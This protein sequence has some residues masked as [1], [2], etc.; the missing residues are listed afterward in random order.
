MFRKQGRF[1]KELYQSFSRSNAAAIT[2]HSKYTLMNLQSPLSISDR[3]YHTKSAS[4]Y[5]TQGHHHRK[6]CQ[7]HTCHKSQF[8]SS[9][10]LY[11]QA[12]LELNLDD[13]EQIDERLNTVE[14]TEGTRNAKIDSIVDEIS[15]LNL[16]EV[17]T[18]VT[19]LKAK[20]NLPDTAMMGAAM[21]M[22]AMPAA[23]ATA[24]GGE[25]Q[26]AGMQVKLLEI[27]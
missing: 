1:S 25:A 2:M 11:E 18:L 19:A 26:E 20:L 16:L 3:I 15:K 23:A 21:P 7:C 9:P 17:A 22:G 27:S 14:Q 24:S 13:N 8:H 5:H 4:Y 12:Q 10:H 6:L